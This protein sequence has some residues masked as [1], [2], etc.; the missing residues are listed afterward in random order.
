MSALESTDATFA[1]VAAERRQL[2]D[3]LDGLDEEQWD[4]P[5]LCAGWRVRDVAAHLLMEVSIGA[6]RL[7]LGLAANR[8][9]FDRFAFRWAV[10]E[11]GRRSDLAERFRMK[12][13]DRFTPPGA[14]PEAPLTHVVSHGQDIRR[15]LGL[16]V[17]V[18]APQADVALEQLASPR[19]RALHRGRFDDLSL[20]STDTGW[21]AGHGPS[22]RG[23]AAALI[24]TLTGRPAALDELEGDGVATLKARFA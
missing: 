4:A 20:A 23:S 5:S 18:P 13:E 8:F 22:V 3:L 10:A 15:A 21:S 9:D 16:V 14:G 11:A 19:A 17:P 2:A 24:T 7:L 6:P 12:A 1:L